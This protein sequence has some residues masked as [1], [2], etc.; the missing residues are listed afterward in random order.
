MK[1]AQ[2]MNRKLKCFQY[3]CNW[4]QMCYLHFWY[5]KLFTDLN[6]QKIAQ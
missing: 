3:H 4:N 6:A 2:K 5:A 1:K